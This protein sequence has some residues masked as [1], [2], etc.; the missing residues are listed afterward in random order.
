LKP[1]PSTFQLHFYFEPCL[2]FAGKILRKHDLLLGA[3]TRD[4]FL[5]SVAWRSIMCVTSKRCRS[6]S[7]S[8]PR[9]ICQRHWLPPS[10][11]PLE[12][13]IVQLM[14]RAQ[15]HQQGRCGAQE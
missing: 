6:S 13:C 12:L 9:T 4:E 2:T 15:V 14:K 7:S 11:F 5:R 3:N 1:Q 10:A 8:R